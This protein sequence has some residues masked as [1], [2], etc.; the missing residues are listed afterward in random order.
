[1]ISSSCR[2]GLWGPFGDHTLCTGPNFPHVPPRQ[3][4]MHSV[5]DV[6]EHLLLRS[7][8]QA[9]PGAD[10]SLCMPHQAVRGA[11]Q[12]DVKDEALRVRRSRG[13]CAVAGL[14][15][16]AGLAT[17]FYRLRNALTLPDVA[18]CCATLGVHTATTFAMATEIGTS[19]ASDERLM[20][21]VSA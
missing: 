11:Q 9:V 2:I 15:W 13:R 18:S 21:T 10:G 8:S 7:E 1:M 5:L 20:F 14:G 3:Q 6:Q 19:R 12:Y 16:S 17:R 4:A